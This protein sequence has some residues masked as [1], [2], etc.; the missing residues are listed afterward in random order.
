MGIKQK[1]SDFKYKVTHNPSY[2][3]KEQL[4]Y[5]GGLFGNA[6]GQD[7]VLTYSDQFNRDFMMI[8]QPHMVLLGN[9]TTILSFIVPPIAGTLLDRPTPNGKMSFTKRILLLTPLPFAITSMMLFLVPSGSPLINLVWSFIF[10]VLFN[11]VDAFFDIALN[12]VALRMTSTN[13]KDRKNFYTISSLAQTLGSM[14]PGWLLPIVVDRFSTAN[15]QRWA[16]FFVALV[17]CV[18]GVSSMS[19]PYFT[20]N[21]RVSN[22]KVNESEKVDWNRQTISAI[23]HNRPY[24][25]YLLATM[26][27]TIRKVTYDLLPFLYKSTFDDYGMKAIIDM[28]SG[29]LS[30][31]GLAL[32]PMLGGKVSARTMLVSSHVYTG[33]FYGLISA[34]AGKKN[35]NLDKMR[36]RRYLVGVMLGLAG[37]PNSGMSAAQKV[38]I[39]DS[40]DYMEWYSEKTWGKPIRS[41][42]IITA[43]GSIVTHF[44]TLTRKNIKEIS[45]NAV[46]YESGK[47]D[48]S[49]KAITIVQSDRTRRGIYWIVSICGLLGNFIPAIIYAFDNHTGERK[50]AVEAELVEMRAQ[51]VTKTMHEIN[52]AFAEPEETPALTEPSGQ[53]GEN[54]A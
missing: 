48:A 34:N 22:I 12:T 21:E 41:D 47:Q 38:L 5:A 8:S 19:A 1:L 42:G 13:P 27:E 26:F 23:L 4:G 30:Y 17:F 54:D 10:T 18:L 31:V 49:G 40:T 14:L 50:K 52:E 53:E 43:V 7:C 39:A 20:L 35:F 44:N 29:T 3:L 51:R 32:V 24:V 16:Y 2:T 9:A 37:L 33:F 28:I 25:I 15:G 36:K 45:L 46:G 6:M 11:T